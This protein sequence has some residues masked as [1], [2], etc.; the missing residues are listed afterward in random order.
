MGRTRY[1]ENQ[2]GALLKSS[3]LASDCPKLLRYDFIAIVVAWIVNDCVRE[4]RCLDAT[5]RAIVDCISG[6]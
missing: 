4:Q 3:D 2:Y 1:L 5:T 6:R